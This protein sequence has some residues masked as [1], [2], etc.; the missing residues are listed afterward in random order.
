[1]TSADIRKPII[2]VGAGPVGLTTALGLDFYGLPVKIFEEDDSLSLDTKAGTIF[3][4]VL[5]EGRPGERQRFAHLTPDGIARK[6]AS[7][8]AASAVSPRR[9]RS[10]PASSRARRPRRPRRRGSGKSCATRPGARRSS[11]RP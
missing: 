2:V 7:A 5:T 11:A 3:R 10:R 9:P 6:A 8:A 4:H 1:M